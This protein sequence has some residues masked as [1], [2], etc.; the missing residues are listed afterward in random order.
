MMDREY[1]KIAMGGTFLLGML[2]AYLW[3]VFS[4]SY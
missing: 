1:I 4:L 2:Y 3:F